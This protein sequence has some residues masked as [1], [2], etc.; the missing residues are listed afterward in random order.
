VYK[1][2]SG[3]SSGEILEYL[4]GIQ[5]TSR[6]SWKRSPSFATLYFVSNTTL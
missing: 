1:T 2:N 3:L 4:V 5:A 6:N